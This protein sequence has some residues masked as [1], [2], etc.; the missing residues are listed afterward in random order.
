V[1]A[2][3]V[4]RIDGVELVHFELFTGLGQDRIE[5]RADVLDRR[6]VTDSGG[7]TT[8]RVFIRTELDLAGM[9][10]PIEI[11]LTNRRNMLFPMLLGRTAMAGR[12]LLDPAQSF[13]LGDRGDTSG[14]S[15]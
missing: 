10:F 4:L 11:N 12:F 14:P 9:R 6:P 8:E 15:A 13:V 5:C 3:D 7:H 2:L 1:E